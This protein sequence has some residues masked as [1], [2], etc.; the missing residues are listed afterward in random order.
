MTTS[1][2]WHAHWLNTIRSIVCGRP[3]GHTRAEIRLPTMSI[4]STCC[5]IGFRTS[6]RA[7]GSLST[8]RRACMAFSRTLLALA[9]AL[10]CSGALAGLQEGLDALRRNDFATAAK[11]L[12]PVAERGDAEAQYRIGLMYEYGKGYPQDKVQGIVWFRKA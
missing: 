8:I 1:A 3:I 9:A 6:Q 2:C 5:S 7:S 10:C 11:E 4:S 12:R